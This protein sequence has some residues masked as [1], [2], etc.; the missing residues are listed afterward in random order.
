M[1]RAFQNIAV[2]AALAALPLG[3]SPL[4]GQKVKSQKEQQAILAVQLAKDPDDRIKAI[5]NVLTNFADTEFKMA[6]LQMAVQTE[7]DKGDY[8]QTV[9]YGD[10]L[11]KADPKNAFAMITIAA[12]T[13]RHTRENDLDKDDQLS[14]V[15]KLAKDGLEAAKTMPKVRAD[16]TDADWEA[17]KKDLSAQAYVALAM[18]D[19]LRKNY[20]G[21]ATNYKQSLATGATPN[22]ATLVRLGQVY[23]GQG[24][25]DD[26]NYTLDK[27]INTP[28]VAPQIK[29]I[30]ENLKAEIA[31]HKP[32]AAPAAGASGQGGTP[33]AAPPANPAPPPA[34]HQP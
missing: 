26:A 3:F 18:A 20:E 15:D 13:A 24:K 6:L 27:A 9:F 29:T 17:Y 22:A 12:E 34:S 19:Q 4:W 2:L 25:L 23:M 5:E 11:L 21:A 33:P 7:V 10:R 31:K 14:K 30:A 28:N 1:K 8:A 32:A 16:V